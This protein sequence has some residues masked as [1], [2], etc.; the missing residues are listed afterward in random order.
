M[1][2]A[3]SSIVVNDE[4]ASSSSS[5]RKSHLHRQHPQF[6][7]SPATTSTAMTNVMH[8][9][10][11]SNNSNNN[12]H[13]SPIAN[14]LLLPHSQQQQQ[15]QDQ[16]QGHAHVDGGNSLI[17]LVETGPLFE[18]DEKELVQ[19]VSVT[20]TPGLRSALRRES[21][22]ISIS[23]SISLVAN[24]SARGV[25]FVVD[26]HPPQQQQQHKYGSEGV[27]GLSYPLY[28][29]PQEFYQWLDHEDVVLPAVLAINQFT[30]KSAE[31]NRRSLK[32]HLSLLASKENKMNLVHRRLS[33]SAALSSSSSSSF[34]QHV[35]MNSSVWSDVGWVPV[36]R[37][38]SSDD[39]GN[40]NNIV[41]SHLMVSGQI[42]RC[43][44]EEDL[45]VEGIPE[46]QEMLI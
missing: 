16:H 13:N 26:E 9:Q 39:N 34:D 36:E 3:A 5:S 14:F 37:N 1:G 25:S 18:E 6:A 23:N 30:A 40:N 29:L 38:N 45:A 19:R 4:F 31:L 35:N 17:P 10:H 8:N 33:N 32:V 11:N 46:E 20:S 28:I 43:V 12:N 22:S 44:L 24:S 21:P 27:G 2:C 42:R 7:D 15:Q 41:P